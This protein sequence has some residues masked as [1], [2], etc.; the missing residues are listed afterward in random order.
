MS[1]VVSA[2]TEI[3]DNYDCVCVYCTVYTFKKNID[4]TT[5][6][7]HTGLKK[8]IDNDKIFSYH[9]PRFQGVGE[10]GLKKY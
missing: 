1:C 3:P 2:F 4:R 5:Y 7:I 9:A 10:W 8:C 6:K